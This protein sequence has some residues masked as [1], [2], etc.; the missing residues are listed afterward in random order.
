MIGDRA[1]AHHGHLSYIPLILRAHLRTL[2]NS[3]CFAR[4][5]VRNEQSSRR[6]CDVASNWLRTLRQ[7]CGGT[8]PVPLEGIVPGG[9]TEY[10]DDPIHELQ[11]KPLFAPP[12][13]PLDY[14]VSRRGKHG[15]VAALSR[16]S[17][18]FNLTSW[19]RGLLRQ[20][21]RRQDYQRSRNLYHLDS[22]LHAASS[23]GRGSEE[24]GRAHV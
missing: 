19:R 24:I 11:T 16:R 18:R 8:Y 2:Q 4:S 9:A 3:N 13:L 12:I 14:V 22:S 17:C 23:S 21:G 7:T 6:S 5:E 15:P 1:N 10:C 20:A